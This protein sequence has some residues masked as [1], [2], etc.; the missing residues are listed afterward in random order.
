MQFPTTPV[1]DDFNR[2]DEGPPPSGEWWT[3]ESGFSVASNQCVPAD[4]VD[5]SA[6]WNQADLDL[7]SDNQEVYITVVALPGTTEGKYVEIGWIDESEGDGYAAALGYA[8]GAWYWY[9]FRLDNFAPTLLASGAVSAVAGCKLGMRTTAGV[10]AVWMDLGSGWVQ[11]GSASDSTYTVSNYALIVSN[12]SAVILDDFGGGEGTVFIPSIFKLAPAAL[13]NQAIALN[14]TTP[15]STV[16]AVIW[17]TVENEPLVWNGT[18]WVAFGV[19]SSG[20]TEAQIRAR[21][22]GA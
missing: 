22:L 21:M 4:D 9:L 10:H 11:Q 17:S 6:L 13:S 12:S 5:N 16:G 19:G 7:L 2:A 15:T 1:L 8:S 3:L 18:N 14:A 20:L